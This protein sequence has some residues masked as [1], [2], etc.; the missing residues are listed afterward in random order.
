MTE[1]ICSEPSVKDEN[2]LIHAFEPKGE[3]KQFFKQSKLEV[4]YPT[5]ISDVQNCLLT[6]PLLS[7][8]APVAWIT[9][10]TLRVKQL[11]ERA[12]QTIQLVKSGY[13]QTLYQAGFDVS[14]S[15]EVLIDE[16]VRYDGDVIDSGKKAMLF[17]GG[18][19]STASFL[20]RQQE[21]PALVIVK[22][23]KDSEDLWVSRKKNIEAFANYFNTDYL[24]VE[25]NM[26][27]NLIKGSEILLRSSLNLNRSW[28]AGIQ[29]PIGYMGLLAPLTEA[30]GFSTLYQSSGAT[31]KSL[32][33]APESNP[34]IVDQL[35]WGDTESRI[36][37]FG[38]S[39]Q[40]KVETIVNRCSS[41]WP[42]IIHSCSEADPC[43]SC[44]SCYRNI[45]GIF[46][47]GGDP[48]A[49]GHTMDGGYEKL[50][51]YFA[52]DS[53]EFSP[54]KVNIW[55]DIQNRLDR[56]LWSG[57]P[58]LYEAFSSVSI[59]PKQKP[60]SL[61]KGI[62]WGLPQPINRIGLRMYR[63]MQS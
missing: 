10:N 34:M 23:E 53:I 58:Q 28:W 57:P 2:R 54:V 46:T 8:L 43:T 60:Q 15:G 35:I 14:F 42:F 62:Y 24:V 17:T 3:T 56:N 41:D 26:R 55:C 51:E 27:K 1:I 61:K 25:S 63:S 33:H 16:V 7:N 13:K 32:F 31:G 30:E 39:R 45:M 36:V 40:N 11:D 38:L 44:E 20:R 29:Y 19:D 9:G 47:A 6:I 49:L 21:T 37:D 59:Q 18:V 22:R 52:T 5:D 50:I 12:A 48:E 4:K